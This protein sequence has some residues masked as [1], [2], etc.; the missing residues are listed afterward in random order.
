MENEIKYVVQEIIRKERIRSKEACPDDEQLL[1]YMA[2]FLNESDKERVERHLLRCKDCLNIVVID[3]EVKRVA[4]QE[5]I[6][7]VTVAWMEKAE[8]LYSQEKKRWGVL[9]DAVL[10]FASDTIE[11]MKNPG[12]LIISYDAIPATLRGHHD[13]NLA[14]H[15]TLSKTFSEIKSETEI[16]RLDND[17]INITVL[18]TRLDSGAPEPCVRVSIFN[19]NQELASYIA[20]NGFVYF[21]DLSLNSYTI[22]ISR[23][24]M[25]L[26]EIRLDLTK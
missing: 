2:G 5:S 3:S 15:V 26:G 17:H 11:V 7:Q 25:R 19:P 20:E 22:R 10:K 24:H 12:N 8:T 16:E 23:Q 18:A 13:R 4:Q 21:P 9:V 14:N 6:P 1:F